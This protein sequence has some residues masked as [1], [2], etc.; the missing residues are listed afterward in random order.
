VKIKATA[1][2][3]FLILR[4]GVAQAQDTNNPAIPM[5]QSGSQPEA[6][7]PPTP[8]PDLV[9]PAPPAQPPA[10]PVQTQD[11]T[12]P[13]SQQA[14]APA[15]TAQSGQWV[16]TSDYGWLWMP[17]GNQYTYEGS[18]NDVYPYSY[19]YYPNYGWTWLPAPWVWGWG[20]HPYF[21]VRGPMRFGW[22]VGLSRSGYGWG[23]YRGGGPGGTA[24]GVR[25]GNASTGVS[26]AASDN[27]AASGS[28]GSPGSVMR[29]GFVGR[30]GGGHR[31]RR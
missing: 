16:Y 27:H 18:V 26:R 7:Q 13:Q 1:A 23:G 15:P 20:A 22:Y 10:P 2:L 28:R 6:V 31:G 30:A 8:P 17:Y 19:V 5:S 24:G 4:L 25:G 29:G 14:S 9:P 3:Y 21:G 11:Q 12:E